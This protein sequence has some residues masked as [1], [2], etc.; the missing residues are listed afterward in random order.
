M[1]INKN[2]LSVTQIFTNVNFL[3]AFC[4]LFLAAALNLYYHLLILASQSLISFS[5]CFIS[6]YFLFFWWTILKSFLLLTPKHSFSIY[7]FYYLLCKCILREKDK[8]LL[9]L[10][11]KLISRTRFFLLNIFS[12]CFSNLPRLKFKKTLSFL[13]HEENSVRGKAFPNTLHQRGYC[14]ST[15]RRARWWWLEIYEEYYACLLFFYAWG[16]H[17]TFENF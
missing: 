10:I 2:V 7:S 8:F 4:S 6:V 1:L 14:A 3:P 15:C 12:V 16:L 9:Q 17:T 5:F 13:A 11:L